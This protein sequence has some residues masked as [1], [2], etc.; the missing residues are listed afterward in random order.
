MTLLASWGPLEDDFPEIEDPPT[1][2]ENIFET[3]VDGAFKTQIPRPTFAFEK[4]MA[5]GAT[6][7]RSTLA[8]NNIMRMYFPQVSSYGLRYKRERG[9]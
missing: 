9:I 8:D 6:L 4:K 2:K 5:E 7:F 3:N 1:K